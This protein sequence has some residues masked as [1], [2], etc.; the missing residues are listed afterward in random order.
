MAPATRT[1][2]V[3]AA[4]GDCVGDW[5]AQTTDECRALTRDGANEVGRQGLTAVGGAGG[6]LSE[7][8]QWAETAAGGCSVTSSVSESMW[9]A[10]NS[11]WLSSRC[12]C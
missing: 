8:S 1:G 10:W 11:A 9:S 4:F 12:T 3:D 2:G 6:C 7:C 5:A